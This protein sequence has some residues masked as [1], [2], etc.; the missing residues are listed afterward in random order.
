MYGISCGNSSQQPQDRRTSVEQANPK[1][2]SLTS[3]PKK[4]VSNIKKQVSKRTSVS[5]K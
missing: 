2:M 5:Y 4:Q 3:V 1:R